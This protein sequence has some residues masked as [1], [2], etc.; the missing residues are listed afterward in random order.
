MKRRVGTIGSVS[1]SINSTNSKSKQLHDLK[2]S[3]SLRSR[4]VHHMQL[5]KMLFIVFIWCTF[6]TIQNDIY[7]TPVFVLAR[8][9]ADTSPPEASLHSKATPLTI[10]EISLLRVRDIKRRLSRYHGYSSVEI[11]RM[12]DKKELIEAL[13]FEEHKA[14]RILDQKKEW[15]FKKKTVIVAL[16]AVAV[17][18]FWPFF[19]HLWEI[20]WVN[21]VVY[22]DKK[23]YEISRCLSYRS[24]PACIGVFLMFIID[25]LLFWLSASIF[26][27][28]ILPRNKYMFPTPSLPIRP[29][30]ILSSLSSAPNSPSSSFKN[31]LDGYG[32]NI[33]PMLITWLFQYGKRTIESWTGKVLAR[34]LKKDRKEKKKREKAFEKEKEK[35]RKREEELRRREEEERKEKLM[36]RMNKITN[37]GNGMQY[38]APNTD[39]YT[40]FNELD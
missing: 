12:L 3:H 39:D 13:A 28:W 10:H 35:E 11:S 37:N 14:Q 16:S 32:I 31:P 38:S 4:L 40:E 9:S 21:F 1:T 17:V 22:T 29:T 20:A 6:L 33:A 2:R 19:T 7:A 5:R 8:D 26:L 25:L 36:K 18:I 30:A 34:K 27:S 23:K 24:V 15:E